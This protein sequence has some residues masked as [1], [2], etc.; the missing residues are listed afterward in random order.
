MLTLPAENHVP[1]LR[2]ALAKFDVSWPA[3]R[4]KIEN[5]C[6]SL[7]GHASDRHLRCWVRADFFSKG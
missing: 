2:D 5:R 4:S 6:L 7:A 3:V 1:L